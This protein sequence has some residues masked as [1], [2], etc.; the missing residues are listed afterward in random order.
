M[1][2]SPDNASE[3]ETRIWYR[4]P[5]PFL[6]ELEQAASTKQPV[7]FREGMT[8]LSVVINA[9]EV[10]GRDTADQKIE[11]SGTAGGKPVRGVAIEKIGAL[12]VEF[13]KQS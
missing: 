12:Y 7:T 10:S 11:F 6:P 13:E 9:L 4:F 3:E 8:E 2:E 5:L 1:F